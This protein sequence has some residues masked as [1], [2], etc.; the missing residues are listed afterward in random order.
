M[1]YKAASLS[2]RPYNAVIM[3]LT[4]PGGMGGKEA[5]QH[6]LAFDSAA[7]LKVSSGY[8]N[9]PVMAEYKSYGFCAAVAKPCRPDEIAR[10][11]SAFWFNLSLKEKDSGEHQ[12]Y[13][14][15]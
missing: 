1:L 11:L 13:M 12:T 15:I 8:S 10:V 2:N 3:D 4:I 5:A 7:S 9:D 14:L 6:I